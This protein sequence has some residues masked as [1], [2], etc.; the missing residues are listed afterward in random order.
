[1]IST[2]QSTLKNGTLLYGQANNIWC[3]FYYNYHFGHITFMDLAWINKNHWIAYEYQDIL[4]THNP[5]F[6]TIS[7]SFHKSKNICLIKFTSTYVWQVL[8]VMLDVG[9]NNQR[10]LEDRLCE[11]NHVK[12]IM[13]FYV[14]L[15]KTPIYLFLPIFTNV[16]QGLFHLDLIFMLINCKK[17]ENLHVGMDNK[18]WFF[19]FYPY[20]S[21][22]ATT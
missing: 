10:L 6:V 12:L 9:T 13:H 17:I 16:H 1:M 19:M 5:N 3:L 14:I 15:L 7:F 4:A 8:P 18:Y 11:S 21:G 2:T 22:I 20:R